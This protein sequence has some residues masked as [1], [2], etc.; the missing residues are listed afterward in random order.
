MT[1]AVKGDTEEWVWFDSDNTE[2]EN[3]L[4]NPFWALLGSPN[5]N[6]TMNLLT[7]NKNSL[8]GKT[9]AK[10][11]VYTY[12]TSGNSVLPTREHMVAMMT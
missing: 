7:D 3:E 9:V 6:G 12:P 11:G 8:H 4:D 2:Y 10:I 5:G 1:R